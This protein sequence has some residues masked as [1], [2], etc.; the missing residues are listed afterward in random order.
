MKKDSLFQKILYSKI[1]VGI[2][3]ILIILMIHPVWSMF[4]RFQLSSEILQEKKERISKLED[5]KE[6]LLESIERFGTDEGLEEEI[7]RR[8]NA[9]KE[10]EEM[11]I[12]IDNRS[13]ETTNQED[14]VDSKPSWWNAV[15]RRLPFN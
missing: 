7:R 6:V 3:F 1:T 12:I 13:L 14:S 8:F 15:K 10:G 5:R 4:Q 9:S 2:L 11:V